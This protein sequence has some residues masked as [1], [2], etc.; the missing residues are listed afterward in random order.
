MV[1]NKE[2]TLNRRISGNDKAY[3][4]IKNFIIDNG[5][6]GQ[7]YKITIG[8]YHNI[9]GVVSV[10]Q[11]FIIM[12]EDAH[13]NHPNL[14]FKLVFVGF[15]MSAAA[16]LYCYFTFGPGLDLDRIEVEKK[17]IC[18]IYHKPRVNHVVQSKKI[19]IFANNSETMSFLTP[20]D[21]DN[22]KKE[23]ESFDE[24]LELTISVLALAD[25]P[26]AMHLI[27][28]YHNNGDMAFTFG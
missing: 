3:D 27:N 1:I 11:K 14:R 21:A 23:T 2:F 10:M 9:G 19:T 22:L 13:L 7:E 17:P 8:I 25:Y 15:A 28:S 24:L 6:N 16:Y 26:I 4:K 20:K 12:L 18:I 5:S